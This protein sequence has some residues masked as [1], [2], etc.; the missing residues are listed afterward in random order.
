MNL[1]TE[2]DVLRHREADRSR[3]GEVQDAFRNRL[4]AKTSKT[5][6]MPADFSAHGCG[7][8][9]YRDLHILDG[10]KIS[11]VQIKDLS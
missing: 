9:P 1:R 10:W 7:K 3:D 8:S 2:A 5:R 11:D 4:A 6:M